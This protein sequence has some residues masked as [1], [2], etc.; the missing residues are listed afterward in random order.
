M[1]TRNATNAG[2]DRTIGTLRNLATAR[3][4]VATHGAQYRLGELACVDIGTV[5]SIG[6]R[7]DVWAHTYAGD[8]DEETRQLR[9]RHLYEA[10][11]HVVT[12]ALAQLD[13]LDAAII[14]VEPWDGR[15]ERSVASSV[16]LAM[17]VEVDGLAPPANEPIAEQE[18]ALAAR[19]R[20]ALE[21]HGLVPRRATERPLP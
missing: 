16:E 7:I 4:L 2:R 18:R 8:S 3:Q 9:C 14:W 11:R 20:D 5:P 10:V 13:A 12:A 17:R 15:I 6:F 1:N 21:V 19:V